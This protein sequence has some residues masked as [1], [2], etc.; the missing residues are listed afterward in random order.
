MAQKVSRPRRPS[1]SYPPA[2]M[3]DLRDHTCY[4]LT[5]SRLVY[6]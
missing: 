3:L 5:S 4:N 6:G 1:D 2:V